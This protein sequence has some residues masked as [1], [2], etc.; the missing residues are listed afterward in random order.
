MVKLYKGAAALGLM[1]LAATAWATPKYAL[2]VPSQ[3]TWKAGPQIEPAHCFLPLAA[4]PR[5]RYTA[6]FTGPGMFLCPL[7][8]HPAVC[9][10]QTALA[11]PRPLPSSLLLPVV[12]PQHRPPPTLVRDTSIGASGGRNCGAPSRKAAAF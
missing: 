10:R 9:V 8:C 6:G 12:V 3:Q 4:E 5:T 2:T 1:L 11:V 7:L